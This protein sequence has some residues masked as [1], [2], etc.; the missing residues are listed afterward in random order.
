MPRI[1]VDDE[2]ETDYRF[3]TL[4]FL[5]SIH[6]HSALGHCLPVWRHAA[7]KRTP[8]LSRSA[9]DAVSAVDGF[10]QALVTSELAATGLQLAGDRWY[11]HCPI[12]GAR[13]NNPCVVV[14]SNG[15]VVVDSKGKEKPIA[16]MHNER[17]AEPGTLLF[18]ESELWL[19]GVE[20]RIQWLFGQ[21]R[22]SERG[23][24]ARAANRQRAAAQLNPRVNP[25]VNP[26]PLPLP[27]PSSSVDSNPRVDHRVAEH[28]GPESIKEAMSRLARRLASKEDT[29]AIAEEERRRTGS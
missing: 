28:D 2:A 22:K 26:L 11:R 9:I 18:P 15:C 29:E 20:D 8:I 13:P 6:R 3:Q 23:V 4:G 5:L 7:A 19:R 14:D 25:V 21:D 1:N 24:A 16:E 12:C 17:T 10:A 27:T